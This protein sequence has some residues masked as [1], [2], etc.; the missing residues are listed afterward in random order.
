MQQPPSHRAHRETLMWNVLLLSSL[1][2][3]L[4]GAL[5]IVGV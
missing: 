2:V 3:S 1:S 5:L 4:I